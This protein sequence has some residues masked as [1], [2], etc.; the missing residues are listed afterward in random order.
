MNLLA[1][2]RNICGITVLHVA[3]CTA[4]NLI[5]EL[6]EKIKTNLVI[7]IKNSRNVNS[8]QSI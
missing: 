8:L 2:K 3:T 1:Y 7:I 5:Q 4:Q 6:Y